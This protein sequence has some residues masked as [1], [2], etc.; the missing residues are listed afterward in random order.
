MSYL[1]DKMKKLLKFQAKTYKIATKANELRSKAHDNIDKAISDTILKGSYLSMGIWTI[2]ATYVTDSDE[3]FKFSLSIQT[4]SLDKSW[5]N[6]LSY[7][8]THCYRVHIAPGITLSNNDD[9]L[10]IM[11]D[12]YKI[13]A[14]FIKKHG[15]QVIYPDV[16]NMID[17]LTSKIE[18]LKNLRGQLKTV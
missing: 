12:N 9:V 7:M 13:L 17:T 10:E 8:R 2:P 18:F 5:S 1:D 3:D 16:D 6:I 11:A 4:K 15:M 14:I